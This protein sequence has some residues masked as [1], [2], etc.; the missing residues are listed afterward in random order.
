MRVVVLNRADEEDVILEADWP[1]LPVQGDMVAVTRGDVDEVW[2]VADRTF[3]DGGVPVVI[4]RAVRVRPTAP[5][6]VGS[7]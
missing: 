1:V 6:E 4:V 5:G 7:R 3:A 2:R